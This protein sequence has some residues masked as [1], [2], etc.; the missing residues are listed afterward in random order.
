MRLASG[1]GLF[2]TH[3]GQTRFQGLGHAAQFLNLLNMR[4][5]AARQFMGQTLD[6]VRAAPR[7]NNV[8][9]AGFALEEQLCIAGDAGAEI[10]RQGNGFIQRIGM[11]RLG[12]TESGG[13]GFNAGS[14][15]V[16]ERVLLLQAPA[17]CLT[18]G[19]QGH[20]L[21][22]LRLKRLD[23]FGPQHPRRP[24]LGDL[25]KII[26]ANRPEKRQPRGKGIDVQPSLQSCSQILQTIRQGVSEFNVGGGASFLDVIAADADAVEARHA[27][28]GVGENIGDNSH[29]RRRR[30]DVSIAYHVFLED[31]IL[32]RAG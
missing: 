9:D 14:R 6:Q 22:I 19:S 2:D 7:I 27:A 26:H 17:R 10:G 18:V 16:V 23:Q 29:R 15:R 32:N 24:H 30:I 12:M 3:L 31:V 11:Q 4:P 20:R 28:G 8:G 5:G 13:H 25:H 21:G 1:G